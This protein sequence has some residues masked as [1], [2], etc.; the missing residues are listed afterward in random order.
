V[1][2]VDVFQ[3]SASHSR[4][5]VVFSVGGFRLTPK[6]GHYLGYACDPPP[7]CYD[8]EGRPEPYT[9][10]PQVGVG[11]Y[12]SERLKTDLAVAWT[13]SSSGGARSDV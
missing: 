5:D 1:R 11:F 3:S 6:E 2:T 4:F 10:A 8:L 9:W 12:S 7:N 13:A